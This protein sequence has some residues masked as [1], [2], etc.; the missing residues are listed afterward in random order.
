M[1]FLKVLFISISI[2]NI[3]C[4]MYYLTN[5]HHDYPDARVINAN[6]GDTISLSCRSE[7]NTNHVQLSSTIPAMWF[8]LYENAYPQALILGDRQLIDDQRFMLRTLNNDRHLEIVGARKDDQGY[9]ICKRGNTIRSSYNLTITTNSCINIIP[10]NLHV[11]INEAIRLVCRI[12]SPDAFN[13]QNLRVQW[14]RNDYP[15]LN[16]A[17][18]LSNY[19]SIDDTLYEILTI[20]K[21]RRT[22]TGIYTCRYGQLLTATAHIIVNQ[23]SSASKSRRLISHITGNSSSLKPS[24]RTVTHNFIKVKYLSSNNREKKN[25]FFRNSTWFFPYQ[26]I[27]S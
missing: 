7:S 6:C 24:S 19:S 11:N 20:R 10:N 18:C 16:I 14:T 15:I 3:S 1:L 2:I 22:D 9:Y 25:F 26:K 12:R 5:F 27:L 17:E 8:R 4:S 13:Q 21:A 23:Y